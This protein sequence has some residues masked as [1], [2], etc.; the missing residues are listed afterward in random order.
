MPEPAK[1][2][3]IA[4]LRRLAARGMVPRVLQTLP[5]D[6]ATDID[7][8]GM[9]SLSKLNLLSEIEERADVRIDER[10]LAGVRT[11]ADLERLLE[12]R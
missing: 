3:V 12:K 2:L 11:I 4:A 7:T 10:T 6:D 8:L 9:D 1:G 5:L